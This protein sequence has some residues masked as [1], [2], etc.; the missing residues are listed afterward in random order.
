MKVDIYIEKQDF[1]EFFKWMN[2]IGLGIY[3]TPK[4]EFSHRMADIKD[5]LRVSLD[6]REYTLIRDVKKDIKEI[7]KTYGPLELDFT[8]LTTQNHLLVIKDILR[9]ANRKDV[10][11]EVVYTALQVLSTIPG[12]S[13]TEAM[14]IAENE[15]LPFHSDNL[16]EDI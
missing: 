13:P 15:W 12:L 8:P 11:E 10:M 9:E 3:S 14:V 16:E 2:R 6:S 1:D 7:Q 4:V 5:P